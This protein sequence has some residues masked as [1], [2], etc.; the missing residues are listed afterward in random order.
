M[1][2]AKQLGVPLRN[3]EA[4]G[5][6]ARSGGRWEQSM[7][8]VGAGYSGRSVVRRSSRHRASLEAVDQPFALNGTGPHSRGIDQSAPAG[9]TVPS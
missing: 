9:G 8:G 1:P 3:E 6:R 4:R 7:N 5:A 2:G